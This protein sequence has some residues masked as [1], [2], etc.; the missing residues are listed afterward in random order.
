MRR[1]IGRRSQ[2][3]SAETAI[4][5]QSRAALPF[6]IHT[7]LEAFACPRGEY[8]TVLTSWKIFTDR[9]RRGDRPIIY[10]RAVLICA[11]AWATEYRLG[12]LSQRLSASA[13]ISACELAQ[14]RTHP[15]RKEQ[16]MGTESDEPDSSLEDPGKFGT[17]A[18]RLH[19]L[20]CGN[21][22]GQI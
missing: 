18:F 10:A 13:L 6:S 16:P 3:Q 14:G 19:L 21:N 12:S 11:V 4:S 17:M 20:T 8:A 15:R 9:L 7:S 22:R 5:G 1:D 2:S